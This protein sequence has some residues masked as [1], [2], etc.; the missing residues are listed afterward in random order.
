MCGFSSLLGDDEQGVT[1][2]D[3]G[4]QFYKILSK[5]LFDCFLGTN[6]QSDTGRK[7]KLRET[8][9]KSDIQLD[10]KSDK[11]VGKHHL[12]V[13]Y[14]D[15]GFLFL[16]THV[17][18]HITIMVKMLQTIVVEMLQSIVLVCS[19]GVKPFIAH[20]HKLLQISR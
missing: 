3:I 9:G 14:T 11:C 12:H 10:I 18:P 16:F 5:C 1:L 4:H 8:L 7:R 13:G 6:Q 17:Y 15:L 19:V 2:Q 20:G